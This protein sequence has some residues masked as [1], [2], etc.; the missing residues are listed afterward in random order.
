LE[1]DNKNLQT[2][3]SK[4]ENGT[5]KVT[6]LNQMPANN[7]GLFGLA[8]LRFSTGISTL[9]RSYKNSL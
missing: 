7:N 4:S 9:G 2:L 8:Y 3:T 6:N 5:I 1:E